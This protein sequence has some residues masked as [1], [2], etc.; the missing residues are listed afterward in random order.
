[1]DL[2]LCAIPTRTNGT[3]TISYAGANRPLWI[4]KKGAQ[5]IE[6]IKATKVAIG[7][8]TQDSQEFKQHDITLGKG[9]TIYMFSDGYADQFGGPK[10][11]KLMTGKFKDIIIGIQHL[12]IKE[13][14]D[15][16]NEF[17]EEWMDGSEQVDDILVIGVKV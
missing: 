14:H 11:K 10:K 15:Y 7:G 4:L 13:Q 17:I 12:S 6:E 5:A 16:L 2:S 8:L 3:T 1:M 9:D